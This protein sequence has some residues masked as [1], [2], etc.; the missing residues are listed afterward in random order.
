MMNKLLVTNLS[1][2]IPTESTNYDYT[3]EFNFVRSIQVI[4]GSTTASFSY[5]VQGSNDGTN[6]TNIG[7]AQSI[8]NNSGSTFTQIDG[9]YDY[10]YYRIAL[11]KTSGALT[12]WSVLVATEMR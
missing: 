1:S 3:A 4:W 12:A 9:V 11:T 2:V 5:Q 6:F 8:T 7:S 10:L